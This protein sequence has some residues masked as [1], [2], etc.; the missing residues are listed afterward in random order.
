MTSTPSA[1]YSP[2]SWVAASS[3][4]AWL[5]VDLGLED[6]RLT[7]CWSALAAEDADQVLEVLLSGGLGRLPGFAVVVSQ[8]SGTRVVARHPAVVTCRRDDQ[9]PTVV[10]AA[11]GRTWTDVEL[12]GQYDEITLAAAPV[13]DQGLRLP[14]AHGITPA[15]LLFVGGEARPVAAPPVAVAPGDEPGAGPQDLPP[16]EGAAPGPPTARSGDDPVRDEIEDSGEATGD[17]EPGAG[18]S[19]YGRLLGA[20]VDRDALLAE[21]ADDEDEDEAPDAGATGPEIP[22]V[23]SGH[24]AIWQAEPGLAAAADEESAVALPDP[25]AATGV[26]PAPAATG[27]VIDG[28]PWATGSTAPPGPPPPAEPAPVVVSPGFSPP[29]PAWQPPVALV[30]DV[31][32]TSTTA[33]ASEVAPGVVSDG[34][35][36]TEVRTVNRAELL[37]SLAAPA[38]TGPT[39]MAVRCPRS[40]LTSAYSAHCRVCGEAIEEQVPT[41]EPRPAL[42]RLLLSTG[43]TVILDRD[44]ILGRAPESAEEDPA[45]RPNLVRLTDSGEVS[46]MH[47]RV[48]LDGWQP[49][50]RD[51]GSSNGTTLALSSSSPQ[52]LRP[53]EDY[54]LEPGCEVS[55]ADVVSFRFDVTE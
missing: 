3:A 35:S 30:P 53:Q 45:L 49:M 22:T 1:S 52:Q 23:A 40:H 10:T 51:L 36:E 12:P 9:E 19:Y 25:P 31:A 44:V 26:A 48:T 17:D 28:V 54:V 50:L 14:L 27:G 38:S 34:T 29:T 15:G 47:V 24:T 46:R 13:A 11:E 6:P 8:P 33:P 32:P 41:E 2:G 18:T 20:T 55:L 21:L 42:G 4:A 16:Q 43:E 39:V 37:K 5:L 7:E